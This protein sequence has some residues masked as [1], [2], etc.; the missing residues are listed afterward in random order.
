[1]TRDRWITLAVVSA[2]T[3]MLLL[4]VTV[5]YVALPAIQHDLDA[6]FAELQWVI[7]AYTVVLAA[8]LLSAG[9][10]ADRHGRRRLFAGGLAVFT[11]FS[12]LCG[13]APTP[14]VLDVAR[15]AQGIGAAAMFAASLAL[16]AHEFQGTDRGFAFG[17]WG[18]ITGAALAVG[19]L[20]GGLVV[21]GLSWRWIFLVNLPIGVA[22]IGLTLRHLPESL[23]RRARPLD[24][25][26]MSTF[27]AA[28][29]LL[30]LA[31]IRGN[32]DG[33]SSAPVL[34]A[35][36]A[37]TL[38]AGLFIAV[39]RRTAHPMLPLELFRIPAFSGTALV[40][41]A[42]SVA[43]YP[44]LL[45]LA[46]YLQDVLALSPTETGLRLLPMT[47]AIFAIAPLSGRL[48]GR[49]PL[50]IPLCAGLALFGIALLLMHGVQRGDAWTG[51]LPG[52]LVG[53][54]AV[55][56]ISP[57]LAAA[58]VAVLPVQRS[59]L[60][61]GVNNT[62]RQLGIALGIAGLGAIFQRDTGE[63]VGVIDGLNAVVLVAA[64]VAIGAA[65]AAWPLLGAQKSAA[66]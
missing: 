65:L 11:L 3:A 56:L 49:L 39:E 10:L 44:L 22:L 34:A 37:A 32:A 59:G 64:A 35:F 61:S 21:D 47:L 4:D 36:A 24:L 30:V 51:L 54:A 31:L 38:L 14:F 27:A 20:V 60:S 17:V 19:P 40:A 1:V 16:L 7:D 2:A 57:A 55:G 13:L 45:F 29:A 12:T 62:F 53:G 41:F 6:T 25:A 18:A 8:T 58:M 43:I 66:T 42:Q 63:A 23:D 15:A 33:W 50:R 26:G 5:V 52:M 48:T 46:I 28:A 9:A